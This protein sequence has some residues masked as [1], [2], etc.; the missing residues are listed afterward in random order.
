MRQL[1]E[2]TVR[3][4]IGMMRSLASNKPISLFHLEAAKEMEQLLEE[5]LQYRKDKK[6]V[7]LT[8]NEVETLSYVAEGNTWI[9]IELAETK[10]KEKNT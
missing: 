9:A 5:V 7:G 3:L 1:R 8:K 2:G 10:L 4:T 6:W